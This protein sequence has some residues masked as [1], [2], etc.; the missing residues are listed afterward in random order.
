MVLEELWLVVVV[1]EAKSISLIVN[2]GGIG[3]VWCDE[4]WCQYIVGYEA[5]RWPGAWMAGFSRNGIKIIIMVEN[6]I[7]CSDEGSIRRN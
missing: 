2:F 6:V 5:E 1:E 4:M 7:V 3:V